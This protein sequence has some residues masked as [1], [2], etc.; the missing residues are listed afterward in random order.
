M[1]IIPIQELDEIV[2]DHF[3]SGDA[4]TQS[5]N[6]KAELQ[7]QPRADDVD[8]EDRDDPLTGKN[9]SMPLFLTRCRYVDKT[10]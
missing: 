8:E 7:E 5:T 2:N 9:E 4:Q 1:F 10:L 6:D 3:G